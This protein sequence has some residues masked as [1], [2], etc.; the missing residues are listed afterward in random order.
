VVQYNAVADRLCQEAGVYTID[1]Y[2]FTRGL[3][4]DLFCDHVHFAERVREM[5]AAFIAGHLLAWS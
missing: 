5:Q 3:G 4:G 1:L 2:G